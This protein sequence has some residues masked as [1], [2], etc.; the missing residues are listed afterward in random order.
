MP[1]DLIIINET[2]IH[3]EKDE[4]FVTLL[5]NYDTYTTTST[6]H[7]TQE[8]D[9]YTDTQSTHSNNYNDKKSCTLM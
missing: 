4:N 5:S 6:D 9:C 3:S 2:V 7:D 1:N 8:E